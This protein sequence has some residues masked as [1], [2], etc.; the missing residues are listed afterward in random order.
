MDLATETLSEMTNQQEQKVVINTSLTMTV[1]TQ[2]M[3]SQSEHMTAS[4]FTSSVCVST[5]GSHGVS[6][7]YLSDDEDNDDD[8]PIVFFAN[9]FVAT[10]STNTRNATFKSVHSALL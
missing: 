9:S 2:P 1:S 5:L 8:D 6:T 3:T 4:A 7:D 10:T